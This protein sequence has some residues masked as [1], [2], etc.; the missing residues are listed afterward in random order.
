MGRASAF[1]TAG[2][3]PEWEKYQLIETPA[4]VTQKNLHSGLSGLLEDGDFRWLGQI[5]L[6]R[7]LTL[8]EQLQLKEASALAQLAA[9]RGMLAKIQ[10]HNAP[11]TEKQKDAEKEG[12]R[13]AR[14]NPGCLEVV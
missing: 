9:C 3:L 14:Q 12:S 13:L 2:F 4:G 5:D 7:A 10:P 1:N 11:L 8:A 6:D